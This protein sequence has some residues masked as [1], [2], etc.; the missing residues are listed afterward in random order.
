MNHED[1]VM[2]GPLKIS[3]DETVSKEHGRIIEAS[4]KVRVNYEMDSG[5]TLESFSKFARYDEKAGT[6]ELSGNPKALWKS[7][8]PNRSET[9]LIADKIFLKIKDSELNAKGN[10]TVIQAG[11]T[12]KA[13]EIAYVNAEKKM[14]A[15]GQRPEFD[16]RDTQHHTKISADEIIA[17]TDKKQIHFN[18]KVQG[19]IELT[20]ENKK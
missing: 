17:W 15:K 2:K 16:I 10:V 9:T 13:D 5:D 20:P 1:A 8:D 6:G 4:G 3:A 11:N 7:S 12:L 14:T 18:R 19:I